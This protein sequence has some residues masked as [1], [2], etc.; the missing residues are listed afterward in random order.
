M[1]DI[2]YNKRSFPITTDS[3]ILADI[4][5]DIVKNQQAR[6]LELGCGGG[7]IL[8]ETAKRCPN[9]IFTGIE[10]VPAV[11]QSAEKN[12][13]D[14]GLSDRITIINGDI[15]S[16]AQ[17]INRETFEYVIMNPPYFESKRGRVSKDPIRAAARSDLYGSLNDFALAANYALDFSGILIASMVKSRLDEFREL[18]TRNG[19]R[20]SQT[21]DIHSNPVIYIIAEKL[22]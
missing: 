1:D 10:L 22:S 12:A 6:V 18:L 3:L 2:E 7:I 13:S 9:A 16:I 20:I 14:F 5:S 8:T 21:R 15:R 11:A 19:I 4:V 17:Y